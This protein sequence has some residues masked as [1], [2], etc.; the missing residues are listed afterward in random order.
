VSICLCYASVFG[1]KRLCKLLTSVG[2]FSQVLYPQRPTDFKLTLR[3]RVSVEFRDCGHEVFVPCRAVPWQRCPHD[4][5]RGD[6]L[7]PQLCVLSVSN[8]DQAACF[9]K[10]K[11][12]ASFIHCSILYSQC[13]WSEC[14]TKHGLQAIVRLLLIGFCSGELPLCPLHWPPWMIT[15]IMFRSPC[16]HTIIRAKNIYRLLYKHFYSSWNT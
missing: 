14:E 15:A 13:L 3:T 7:A 8:V 9:V 6:L 16:L 1:S 4:Y 10:N 5:T 2:T 12:P 11:L